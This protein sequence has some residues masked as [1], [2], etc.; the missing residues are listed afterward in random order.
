MS[1]L[2]PPDSL[3]KFETNPDNVEGKTHLA[4]F[5]SWSN[6]HTVLSQLNSISDFP[7]YFFFSFLMVNCYNKGIRLIHYKIITTLSFCNHQNGC[8]SVSSHPY[9]FLMDDAHHPTQ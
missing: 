4:K 6:L 2:E 5:I 9:P 8:P 7:V 1:L 3:H